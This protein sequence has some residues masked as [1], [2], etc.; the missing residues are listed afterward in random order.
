MLG[1]ALGR[2]F[3]PVGTLERLWRVEA[4]RDELAVERSGHLDEDRLGAGQARREARHGLTRLE[5]QRIALVEGLYGRGDKLR[6]MRQ[7]RG[8]VGGQ[9]CERAMQVRGRDRSGQSKLSVTAA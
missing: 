6:S 2:A 8:D 3:E 4:L 1:T 5:L 9:V 7:C